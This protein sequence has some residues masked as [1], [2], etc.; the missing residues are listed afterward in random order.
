MRNLLVWMCVGTVKEKKGLLYKPNFAS[1]V[2]NFH[3]GYEQNS[4]RPHELKDHY[5]RDQETESLATSSTLSS[6]GKCRQFSR[7]SAR[8]WESS[9]IGTRNEVSGSPAE[10]PVIRDDRGTR[11]KA[12]WSAVRTE[13][14]GLH[15]RTVDFLFSFTLYFGKWQFTKQNVKL[16]LSIGE[17]TNKLKVLLEITFF[18]KL[19]E[20]WNFIFKIATQLPI[21][22]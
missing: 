5:F 2:D 11:T 6:T 17:A 20:R 13:D 19:I 18:I 7:T 1:E 8:W 22:K 4:F 15:H 3:F 9:A 16:K 10:R 14:Q 12:M 21:K